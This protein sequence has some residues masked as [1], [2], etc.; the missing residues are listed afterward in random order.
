[1]DVDCDKP[2]ILKDICNDYEQLGQYW[3]TLAYER[4]HSLLNNLRPMELKLL[5]YFGN[6][7]LNKQIAKKF[8]VSVSTI[9]SHKRNAIKNLGLKNSTELICFIVRCGII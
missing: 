5:P 6:G 8:N 1:M 7:F 9:K 4:N 2:C 3:K